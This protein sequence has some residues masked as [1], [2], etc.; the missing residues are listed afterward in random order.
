MRRTYLIVAVNEQL[1]TESGRLSLANV[2]KMVPVCGGPAKRRDLS[3]FRR[4]DRPDLRKPPTL[5]QPSQTAG[6]VCRRMGETGGYENV[7]LSEKSAR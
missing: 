3:G 6:N 7:L 1:A 5:G 2:E 4:C